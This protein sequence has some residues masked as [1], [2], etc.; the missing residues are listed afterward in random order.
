[1]QH[2]LFCTTPIISAPIKQV[3][4]IYPMI[5][6]HTCWTVFDLL[7]RLTWTQ[8]FSLKVWS[9][10]PQRCTVGVAVGRQLGLH[11]SGNPNRFML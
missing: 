3:L 5:T 7:I 10:I 2:P 4:P 11:S 1:M 6:V 9:A 8:F